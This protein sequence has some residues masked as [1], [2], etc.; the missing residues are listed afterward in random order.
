MKKNF[1]FIFLLL[2]SISLSSCNNSPIESIESETSSESIDS[3]ESEESIESVESVESEESIES[4]EPYDGPGWGGTQT[5]N[6][7]SG[8]Y[9]AC[10]GLSGNSLKSKL[11]SINNPKTPSYDWSRYEAI[12]EAE[13]A[14]D[15]VFC[16]Y[17]RHN[18][19]KNSHVGSYSWDTWNREHVYVQSDFSNAK[20]DNHNVFACEGKINNERGNLKFGDVENTSSNRITVHGHQTDCYKTKS[21]FEPCDD[22]KGE[23][24]RSLMYGAVTY[25]FDPTRMITSIDLML[26]W[27]EEFPV[28]N[29]EIYRNNTAYKLQGNRNPF[30]D[31][32]EY[33]D[34]IW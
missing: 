12:D 23:I 7:P 1:S 22:A 25:G 15:Y 21:L 9:S 19:K 11:K 4:E 10:E 28:S 17:T 5:S 16:V 27:H 32:P 26:E 18:I 31:H 6:A 13:G 33:G 2:L 20:P 34:L 24:A 8:Y 30:V 29:R 3:I 14:P